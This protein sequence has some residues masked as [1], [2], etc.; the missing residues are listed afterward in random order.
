[1]K[2]FLAEFTN[3]GWQVG[4]LTD[5][6]SYNDYFGKCEGLNQYPLFWSPED[7]DN[8]ES[9]STYHPFGGWTKPVK[10]FLN[11]DIVCKIPVVRTY[12]P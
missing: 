11:G 3:S 2:R 1:M 10:K 7:P 8:D 5:Q 12:E 4:L 6:D 9:F